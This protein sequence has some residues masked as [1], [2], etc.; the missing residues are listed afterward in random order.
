MLTGDAGVGK[1]RL[2]RELIADVE[3][4]AVALRGRCLSYGEGITFWP[5]GEIV[6]AAAGIDEA[7]SHRRPRGRSS[8]RSRPT[9]TSLRVSRRSSG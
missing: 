3:G 6:R 7:D 8:S 4:V 1:S 2:V 5:I 9:A